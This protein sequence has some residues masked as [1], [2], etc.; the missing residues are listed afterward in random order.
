MADRVRQCYMYL[1]AELANDAEPRIAPGTR[2]TIVPSCAFRMSPRERL[3]VIFN[4]QQFSTLMIK[5][6]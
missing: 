4:S 1:I 5:I 2:G 3:A 6:F